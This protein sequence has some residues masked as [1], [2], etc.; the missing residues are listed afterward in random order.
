MKKLSE[1]LAT[2]ILIGSKDHGSYDPNE[3]LI[4]VGESM[5]LEE[6]EVAEAFLLYVNADTENRRFGHGNIQERFAEFSGRR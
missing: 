4:R 1:K 2:L 3:A 5:T 6:Y